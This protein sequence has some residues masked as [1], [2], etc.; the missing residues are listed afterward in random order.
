MEVTW[1]WRGEPHAAAPHSHVSYT[2]IAPPP[3]KEPRP[4]T[5]KSRR[6]GLYQGAADWGRGAGLL[7]GPEDV[8]ASS[9]RDVGQAGAR[10]E[11]SGVR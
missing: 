6:L 11:R 7:Q 3:I 1:W 5:M 8:S 2:Y 4:A 9:G 10:T